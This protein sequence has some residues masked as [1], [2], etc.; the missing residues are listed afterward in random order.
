MQDT[1]AIPLKAKDYFPLLGLV[2]A[3][4]LGM[5]LM[6]SAA[7]VGMNDINNA[8][9]LGTPTVGIVDFVISNMST[10]IVQTVQAVSVPEINSTSSATPTVTATNLGTNTN[11]AT[12]YP[13]QNLFLPTK[14]FIP[15]QHPNNTST[16]VPVHTLTATPIPT[17]TPQPTATHTDIPV[18]TLTP[19]PVDTPTDIPP[20]TI[21]YP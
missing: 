20:P 4:V 17:N 9:P 6:C 18:P 19:I 16:P 11:T 10:M 8:I 3:A 13:T 5:S 2:G 1:E 12:S 21:A 14:T 15:P 7:L